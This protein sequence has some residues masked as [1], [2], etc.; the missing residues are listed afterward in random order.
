MAMKLNDLKDRAKY[1]TAVQ[2]AVKA[3]KASPVE[4]WVFEDFT[5]SDDKAGWLLLVGSELAESALVNAVKNSNA[6]V[7]G[8]GKCVYASGV[9][10]FLPSMGK[11][12]GA[13]LKADVGNVRMLQVQAFS[14][15]EGGGGTLKELADLRSKRDQLAKA[16]SGQKSKLS[17]A[18]RKAGETMFAAAAKRLEAASPT[19][20]DIQSAGSTLVHIERLVKVATDTLPELRKALETATRAFDAGRSDLSRTAELEGQKVLA[21][22]RAAI[23]AYNPDTSGMGAV[24]QQ[25]DELTKQVEAY[26][27]GR[28]MQTQLAKTIEGY[29][30][31]AL[32][33]R[34]ALEGQLKLLAQPAAAANVVQ[35]LQQSDQAARRL[36]VQAQG[37]SKAF[38]TRTLLDTRDL[39]P[40]LES[41]A[42]KALDEVHGW[43]KDSEAAVKRGREAASA[44]K[45][46]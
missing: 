26:Q 8:R 13:K 22:A 23:G 3:V 20:D 37:I 6:V 25:L 14:A 5:F 7:R 12:D 31:Q 17:E 35:A 33:G 39:V 41:L 46:K 28:K 18:Q 30:D 34:K 10:E 43:V 16:F 21:Q 42:R 19:K 4:Y 27:K 40:M 2:K 36:L 32:A 38:R 45:P 9:L 44:S 11:V 1:R 15:A 29:R 24:Q